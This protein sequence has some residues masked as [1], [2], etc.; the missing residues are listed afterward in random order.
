MTGPAAAQPLPATH[1]RWPLRPQ[2]GWHEGV[3]TL[4]EVRGNHQGESRDHLHAGLDIRGDVGQTVYAIVIANANAKDADAAEVACRRQRHCR[5]RQ[6]AYPL[7]LPGDQQ[8]A[9]RPHRQGRWPPG[10]LPAGDYLIRIAARDYR[11]NQAT[12]NGDLPVTLE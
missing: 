9:R 2:D 8:G 1:G 5:A 4:G 7:P 11:G 3:G 10:A 12:A 6:R